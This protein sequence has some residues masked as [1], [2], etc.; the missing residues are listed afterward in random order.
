MRASLTTPKPR[1]KCYVLSRWLVSVHRSLSSVSL[2][3]A[4]AGSLLVRC[5]SELCSFSF[6][7]RTSCDISDFCFTWW[8]SA[9]AR[10][11]TRCETCRRH[12]AADHIY[13]YHLTSHPGKGLISQAETKKSTAAN[14]VTKKSIRRDYFVTKSVAEGGD[15]SDEYF[16][17]STSNSIQVGDQPSCW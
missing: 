17:T 12:P 1:T 16:A 8:Q 4:A 6:T 10:D 14:Y 11:V 13:S 9:D 5:S 15:F 7:R 2:S 3:A